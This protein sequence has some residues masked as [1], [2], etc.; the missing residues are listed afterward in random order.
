MARKSTKTTKSSSK[1]TV[2]DL[3]AKKP[4]KGG[5]VDMFRTTDAA[6]VDMFRVAAP[7]TQT[8]HF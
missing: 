5:A 3:G 6:A 1:A 7:S 4:T 2:Q 8:F